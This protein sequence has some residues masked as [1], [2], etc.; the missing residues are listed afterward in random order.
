[1]QRGQIISSTKANKN[2]ESLRKPVSSS[3]I[4]QF[5]L[6][7]MDTRRWQ[8]KAHKKGDIVVKLGPV[9]ASKNSIGK[10]WSDN[11]L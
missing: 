1:M 6:N 7:E 11:K 10:D 5:D 2:S 4:K 3:T 9:M 8:F